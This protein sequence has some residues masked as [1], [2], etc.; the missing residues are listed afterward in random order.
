MRAYVKAVY[1]LA[2]LL[3]GGCSDHE[4]RLKADEEG[5]VTTVNS[6]VCFSVD[7]GNAYHL[8]AIIINARG[9]TANR[10]WSNFSP[11]LAIV[12]DK[13]CIPP[14]FY[15]FNRDGFFYIRAIFTLGNKSRSIVSALEVKDSRV[16]NVRPND[17][18]MLRPYEEMLDKQ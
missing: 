3:L 17:M 16:S 10:A 6:D 7:N 9:A 12:N 14:S 4:D 11:G 15:S 8:S 5:Y 18:E 13:V 2:G 1:I